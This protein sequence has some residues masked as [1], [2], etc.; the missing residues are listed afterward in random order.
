MRCLSVHRGLGVSGSLSGLA[1]IRF[2]EG[3]NIHA[4]GAVA[5]GSGMSRY[6]VQPPTIPG[7]LEILCFLPVIRRDM[8][9]P[10]SATAIIL[11]E[12]NSF[13]APYIMASIWVGA[14]F[15]RPANSPAACLASTSLPRRCTSTSGKLIFT[16]HTS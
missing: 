14:C 7:S 2:N 8:G 10:R 6:S 16:G 12:E 1:L 13:L 5:G 4:L 15:F 9:K 11:P 3:C